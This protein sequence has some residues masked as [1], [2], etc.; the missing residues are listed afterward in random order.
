[1]SRICLLRGSATALK[2]STVVAARGMEGLYA[3]MGICQ[4]SQAKAWACQLEP[5][6]KMIW[7]PAEISM[8]SAA[9][10]IPSTRE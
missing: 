2:A 6:M 8:K 9:L 4:S 3:Y 1:M 7:A 5:Q 10:M